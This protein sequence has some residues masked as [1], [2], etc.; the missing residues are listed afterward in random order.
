MDKVWAMMD[1]EWRAQL[2]KEQEER[3]L[4]KLLFVVGTL[5]REHG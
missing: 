3:S 1:I 4:M 2:W 5:M